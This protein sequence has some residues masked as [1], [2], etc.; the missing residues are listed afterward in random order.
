MNKDIESLKERIIA[1]VDELDRP[2]VIPTI[3]DLEN[4]IHENSFDIGYETGYDVGWE[5]GVEWEKER[6]SYK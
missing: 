5:N 6:G 4:A 3:C 2:Y 1:W